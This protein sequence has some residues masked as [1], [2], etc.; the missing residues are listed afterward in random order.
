[1][2]MFGF[3]NNEESFKRSEFLFFLDCLFRGY[4]C[5]L[6]RKGEEMPAHRGWWMRQ[7]DIKA[8]VDSIFPEKKDEI[9][10]S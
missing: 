7:S 10:I 4:L 9:K 1:V 3:G 5:L 2:K 6:I 8:V